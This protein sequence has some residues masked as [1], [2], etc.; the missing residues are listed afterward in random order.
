MSTPFFTP[1]DH[2]NQA[3]SKFSGRLEIFT[4]IALGSASLSIWLWLAFFRHLGFAGILLAAFSMI[5]MALLF[6]LSSFYV[7][8]Y[9][10]NQSIALQAQLARCASA[11]VF[12]LLFIP[13]YSG[14]VHPPVVRS[15]LM[16]M[17]FTAL[18]L[19]LVRDCLQESQ[20]L[21]STAPRKIEWPIVEAIVLLS[22]LSYVAIR[23]YMVFG[24]VGQD[25]AYFSQ[26]M[27]TTLHG[28]LFWGSLLQDLLYSH[29][30]TTDFAGHNSPIMFLFLPFYAIAPSPVTLL[31]LRNVAMA[32][33]AYPVFRIAS[34]SV[35]ASAARLWAIA[36]LLVPVIFYQSVF[37]FY[38]LSFVAL[39]LLFTVLFYLEGRFR[40]FAV[41]L[42]FTLMVREDLALFAA[43]LAIVALLQGRKRLWVATPLIA[44]LAWAALSY[45]V[46]LPHALQGASFVTDA[47]FSHLGA[48]PTEMLTH[49]C[50]SP[51]TTVLTHSNIVYL[52]QLL[53]PNG[54][55]LPFGGPL[56]LASLPFLAINLLAGAG[57][58]I[59]TV[60]YAQYSVIPATVLF[61]SAL[62]FY[63]N[64]NGRL[65]RLARLSLPGMHVAP[66][67]TIALTVAT[68]TF[69]TGRAQMNEIAEQPWGAEA[70]QIVAMIPADASLAAPR[71][72]LPAVANRDC[73]YQTHRLQQYHHPVF[74]YLVLDKD[75]QHINAASEYETA[76]REL[77][78]TAPA[79]HQ[80]QVLYDSEEFLVL[81]NPAVHG[82]G[83]FPTTDGAK[84]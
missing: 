81:R 65:A 19:A 12:L 24:Y 55:I 23:K 37:D 59:T 32:A 44:G 17:I 58:C 16:L 48:T 29:A 70:R 3:V 1:A 68:L 26:I 62:L 7:P 76:Y 42:A 64:S 73:L 45:L 15:V 80:Y 25:L 47:C 43:W 52:K 4:P 83:C 51:Q 38:P 60:I 31:L 39:P 71:Y 5:G 82:M 50:K 53:T 35:S 63:S 54:L 13:E 20:P 49:V 8:G 61:V 27:H 9:S 72:M 6:M 11:F 14:R 79:D 78:Y 30:V 57:K 2:L 18:W 41:A 40:P 75:W 33:C 10:Q 84:Q 74:E 22:L 21:A 46:V 28:H 69:V 77:L 66:L 34:L 56:M 67:I 36:Y